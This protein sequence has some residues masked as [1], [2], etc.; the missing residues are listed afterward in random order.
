MKISE[1]FWSIQGESTFAGIPTLFIRFQGCN[2]RCNY[3]DSAYT[4][5]MEA[6]GVKDMTVDEVMAE[7]YEEAVTKTKN[8]MFICITGG[9]P[10][11]HAADLQILLQKLI[12]EFGESVIITIETNGSIKIPKELRLPQVFWIVD[13]KCPSSGHE[14]NDMSVY[15]LLKTLGKQDEIKFVIGDENDFIYAHTIV[16]HFI[17][18]YFL[19]QRSV[20]F[21]PV[22]L[23]DNKEW[24]AKLAQMVLDA[25]LPVRVQIQ[26]HKVIWP[27]ENRGY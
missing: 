9:E 17:P 5:D 2:L 8:N 12:A 22:I 23:D 19:N 13:I 24:P 16:R 11:I 21:S 1:I 4:F 15:G 10:L 25:E 20:I 7:V 3:C 27:N 18:E 14:L 6:E 26:L